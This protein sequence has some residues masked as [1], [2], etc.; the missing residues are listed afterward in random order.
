MGVY[1]AVLGLVLVTVNLLGT[2]E[3]ST[4]SPGEEW[5]RERTDEAVEGELAGPMDTVRGETADDADR[6]R[7]GLGTHHVAEGV[8]PREVGR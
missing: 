8:P 5:T 2:S 6:R 3:G 1:L 4:P 7:V